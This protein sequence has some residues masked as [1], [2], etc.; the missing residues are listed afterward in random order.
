M[1][2]LRIGN[3]VAGDILEKLT[4]RLTISNARGGALP[5]NLNQKEFDELKMQA[6]HFG[7]RKKVCL[8]WLIYMKEKEM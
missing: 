8:L 6:Y 2:A 4:A 1:D 7:Q 3:P 5:G